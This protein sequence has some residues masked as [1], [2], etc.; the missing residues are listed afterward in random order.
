[1]NNTIMQHVLAGACTETGSTARLLR[2]LLAPGGAVEIADQAAWEVIRD[3][4]PSQ[5]RGT[6]GSGTFYYHIHSSMQRTLVE[7]D[8]DLRT[9][10]AIERAVNYLARRGLLVSAPDN[11]YLVRLSDEV[12]TEGWL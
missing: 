12:N 5:F 4:C 8:E 6:E 9:A 3:E 2:E 1:M 7:D 11:H 10:A